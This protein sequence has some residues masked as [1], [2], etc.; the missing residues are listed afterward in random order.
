MSL[1]LESLVKKVGAETHLYNQTLSLEP[2]LNVLLGPTL[3]G[4][5]SLMRLMAG[6]DKPT[7]GRVVLNGKDMTNVPV[8][9]RSVAFVYQ[10]FVNYPS[11]SRFP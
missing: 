7:S 4:K 8:Q 1:V 10:Q 3:A 5:T 9:K 6:L 2:G 11:F